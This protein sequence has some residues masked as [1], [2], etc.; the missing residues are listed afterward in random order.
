MEIFPDLRTFKPKFNVRNFGLRACLSVPASSLILRNPTIN[1]ARARTVSVSQG[2]QV[3]GAV[4]QVDGLAVARPSKAAQHVAAN[5]ACFQLY[6]A[7]SNWRYPDRHRDCSG[8][9]ASS[10]NRG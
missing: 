3:D 5:S 4:N 6:R 8:S 9:R 2:N 1:L 10:C 7:D